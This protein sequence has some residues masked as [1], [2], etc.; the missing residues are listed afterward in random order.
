M[1]EMNVLIDV[2]DHVEAM[3]LEQKIE[4]VQAI[5]LQIGELSSVVPIFLEEYYPTVVENIDCLKESRLIIERIP[6]EGRCGD[7]GTVYNVV[8]Q[9]GYC[10]DCGSFDK[11]ILSGREFIIKEFLVMQAPGE[12]DFP[13]GAEGVQGG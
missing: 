6:G 11:E 13:A 5:V 9:N 7:C 10:P 1:H 3:V 4:K 8:A 12:G 2:V